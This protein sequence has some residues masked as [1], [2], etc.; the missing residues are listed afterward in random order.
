M[1]SRDIG[2]LVAACA[3]LR[4]HQQT[5]PHSA[6]RETSKDSR[7][8]AD[9]LE[10]R[11][12]R[13]LV[14]G[15]SVE[16]NALTLTEH[17]DNEVLLTFGTIFLLLQYVFKI[18]LISESLSLLSSANTFDFKNI[19][20][21]FFAGDTS[22]PY[23]LPTTFDTMADSTHGANELPA[24]EQKTDN[25][26]S[27]EVAAEDRGAHRD[28]SRAVHNLIAHVHRDAAP[29]RG[30]IAY[31]FAALSEAALNA[32]TAN[33]AGRTTG[34][35]EA[36]ASEQSSLVSSGHHIPPQSPQQT[37]RVE[38]A[39]DQDLRAYRRPDELSPIPAGQTADIMRETRLPSIRPLLE[40]AARAQ[41]HVLPL[42]HLRETPNTWV[43]ERDLSEGHRRARLEALDFEYD[44]H[45]LNYRLCCL[46]Q[47]FQ[48]YLCER[49][50]G[51]RM[52]FLPLPLS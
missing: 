33:N 44:V 48:R 46:Q 12:L 42:G 35:I 38:E 39:W 43:A 1:K 49:C 41:H 11:R 24:Q 27:A 18:T 5:S 20:A 29:T 10:V 51:C 15:L 8:V 22:T 31:P 32:H 14:V 3:P 28:V 13:C 26:A 21:S 17:E 23:L 2:H 19:F 47:E 52:R 9:E 7:T 45:E 36:W 34:I 40:I 50:E 37:P 6:Y 16:D 25:M 30:H 4:S